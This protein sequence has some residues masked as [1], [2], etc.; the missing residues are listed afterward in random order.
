MADRSPSL[1][2]RRRLQA[3][4]TTHYQST[5]TTSIYTLWINLPEKDDEQQIRLDWISRSTPFFLGAFGVLFFDGFM[6]VQFLMYASK[7]D[8]SVVEDVLKARFS[9]ATDIPPS[10]SQSLCVR[11][12][13]FFFKSSSTFSCALSRHLVALSSS[14]SWASVFRK[15]LAS[16]RWARLYSAQWASI[17]ASVFR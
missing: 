2:S 8:E 13:E 11:A 14:D 9:I 12:S 6:G 17:F 16:W 5:I 4:T 7:D 1:F 15:V 10:S 3:S